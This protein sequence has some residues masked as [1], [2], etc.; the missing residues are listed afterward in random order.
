MSSIRF[1]FFTLESGTFPG[2]L[3]VIVAIPFPTYCLLSLALPYEADF[4]CPTIQSS[5][6]AVS[7]WVCSTRGTNQ[8]V[9]TEGGRKER[10]GISFLIL[11]FMAVA[12]PCCGQRMDL[13]GLS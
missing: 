4:Y 7:H 9:I 1:E 10:S 2:T 12:Y 3:F 6:L 11:C 5:M 8:L 13:S